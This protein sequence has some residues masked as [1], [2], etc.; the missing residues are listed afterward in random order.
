[1]NDCIQSNPITLVDQEAGLVVGHL[2]PSGETEDR[3]QLRRKACNHS[4]EIGLEETDLADLDGEPE[5]HVRRMVGGRAYALRC[6]PV[7]Q[8][9]TSLFAGSFHALPPP[10]R[11]GGTPPPPDAGISQRSWRS[12]KTRR[13]E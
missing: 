4:L 2:R 7:A 12:K 13:T 6:V 5:K 1:L 8:F 3:A 11:F 9:Q 10:E